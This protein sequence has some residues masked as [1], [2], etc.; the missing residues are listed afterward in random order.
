MRIKH[1]ALILAMTF[2]LSSMPMLVHADYVWKEFYV[3]VGGSDEN[4]GTKEEPFATVSKAKEAV[5]EISAD[6]Q[7]DIVVNIGEGTYFLNETLDFTVEDSGKNGYDIIYRGEKGKM[8]TISGGKRVTGFV[9]SKDHP[10]IYEAEVLG[11]DR[12][13]Q[14]YVNGKRRHMA[15]SGTMLKGV[16]KPQK[17]DTEEWYDSHPEDVRDDHYNYN[18]F[19][20]PYEYDGFYMLKEDIGFYE[21]PEDILLMWDFGWKSHVMPVSEILP[22]PDNSEQV[23]VRMKEGLWN[24]AVRKNS[25]VVNY[26]RPERPFTMMNA[27]E[28]LDEPGEMYFNR[29]TKKLYYMPYSDEN[30]ETAEV[31]V[32]VIENLMLFTGNDIDD[33]VKNITFENIKFA[34]SAW[35]GWQEGIMTQQGAAVNCTNDMICTYVWPNE[36]GG[37][38]TV[39]AA[40]IMQMTDNINFKGNYFFGLGAAGIDAPNGV[41]NSEFV[42]NAFSDL[43]EGAFFLGSTVHTDTCIGADGVSDAPSAASDKRLS[44]TDMVY[45]KISTSY[46]S[47]WD[48]TGTGN[49]ILTGRNF[50]DSKYYPDDLY[51]TWVDEFRYSE[52]WKSDPKAVERGEKSWIKYDFLRKYSIDEVVMAFDPQ[53]VSDAEKSGYEILV[54]NDKL[55]TEGNYK[56][57]AKQEGPAEELQRYKIE[58]NEKYQFL[59]VRTTGATPLAVSRVWA[60]TNDMES[61]TKYERCKNITFANNYIERIGVDIHRAT[62]VFSPYGENVKI[63]HNEI[64]DTGYSGLGTGWSWSNQRYGVKDNDYSYNYF[65]NTTQTMHD[66]GSLYTLGRQVNTKVTNNFIDGNGVGLNAYYSDEGTSGILY[67]NN[68]AESMTYAHSRNGTGVRENIYRNSFATNPTTRGNNDPTLNELTSV[69]VYVAGQPT[70]EVYGIIENAGLEP[71][72]EY[73]RD[74]VS[75]E[76]NNLYD[77]QLIYTYTIEDF[78]SRRAAAISEAKGMVENGVYGEGLGMF[79]TADKYRLKKALDEFSNATESAQI[80]KLIELESIARDVKENINRFGL[81][82]TIEILK[83]TLK[84]A[85]AV[86]DKELRSSATGKN[87]QTDTMG[88]D[89]ESSIDKLSKAIVQIEKNA[90]KVATKEDEFVVLTEAEKAYNDFMSKR[91]SADI[92]Y[93]HTDDAAKVEIDEEAAKVYITFPEGVNL[94]DKKVE[95]IPKGNARVAIVVEE[96]ID[97]TE[98]LNIPLY[99]SAN[100]SY[101]YWTIY[102]KTLQGEGSPITKDS[103]WFTKSNLINAVKKT[104]DSVVL[105]AS[106][107]AY[108]TNSLSNGQDMSGVTFRPVTPN[109][110]NT[111]TF[112]I[113]ANRYDGLDKQGTDELNDRCEIVFNGS[114]ASL[115]TVKSGAKKLIKT[116]DTNVSY[117][118][119]NTFTYS[120]KKINSTTLVL[121]ELNGEVLFSETLEL[122]TDGKYFGCYS[123]KINIEI[124]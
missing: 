119:K 12:I 47:N 24:F 93:V 87:G 70:K 10:G 2:V 99:C 60:F 118:K 15:K 102:A 38:A 72:Y 26:P 122:T 121:A 107:F 89:L 7:G 14:I 58:D 55:F 36:F 35:Y 68:A 75:D 97:L 16:N 71:Q 81:D 1:L 34:H 69:N 40:V 17:Y 98:P 61:H 115:Y 51:K 53:Y 123:D 103:T 41:T 73:I 57:I 74:W 114:E 9:E 120:L 67:E 96:K 49:K 19:D 5:K 83:E 13:A 6:M 52:A 80:A 109:K 111:F 31:V 106:P 65:H 45:Y 18:D 77:K 23:I 21:N 44:L 37:G 91:L 110:N 85:K 54:S 32:P 59:M 95:I 113:G 28:L 29:T 105:T 25:S 116:V 43:G 94:K 20:T 11:V 79:R 112:I 33:K 30:L 8:P 86:S 88:M 39:Q 62:A 50:S 82:E 100:N 108:M 124:Y 92:S 117:N 48:K 84:N 3:A 4:P 27:M 64:I 42:G 56:V 46:L 101:K 76:E 104:E 78:T 63:L 22:N 90:A 66:G